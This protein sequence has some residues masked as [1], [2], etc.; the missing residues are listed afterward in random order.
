MTMPRVWVGVFLC[1][2]GCASKPLTEVVV[3][4]EAEAG[5]QSQSTSLSVVVTGDLDGQPTQAYSNSNA[6][7]REGKYRVVLTPKSGRVSG[8]YRVEAVALK[9]AQTI[10]VARVISGYVAEQTVYVRVLLED[11]CVSKTCG[12]DETC[13]LGECLSAVVDPHGFATESDEATVAVGDGGHTSLPTSEA[14]LPDAETG[15]VPRDGG[16]DAMPGV[17]SPD[18]ARGSPALPPGLAPLNLGAPCTTDAVCTGDRARCVTVT[19]QPGSPALQTGICSRTCSSAAECPAS[20]VC[21]VGELRA[22]V[23][24]EFADTIAPG[25]CLES[26]PLANE[27]QQTCRSGYVCS[28]V[29]ARAPSSFAGLLT[30]SAAKAPFCDLPA[31]LADA[32]VRRDGG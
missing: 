32:G 28:S 11:A 21:P 2:L 15:A 23:P 24:A 29:A 9:N 17:A 1:L 19:A 3:S 14:G 27:T 5:V 30:A 25:V 20:G 10:A 4:I 26:C 8:R 31:I 6:P 18:A 7:W 22:T 12:A 16:A 13:H